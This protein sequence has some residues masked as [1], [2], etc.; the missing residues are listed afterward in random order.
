[1]LENNGNLSNALYSNSYYNLKSRSL[2]TFENKMSHNQKR[3][4]KVTDIIIMV[5]A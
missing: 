4:K 5:L 3:A 2:V 1:M